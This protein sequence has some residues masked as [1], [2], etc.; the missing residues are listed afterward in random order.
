MTLPLFSVGKHAARLRIDD[1]GI[2][3]VLEDV[4]PVL[5]L[6]LGCHT[7]AD[8]LGKPVDVDGEQVELFLDLL[9]HGFAPGL[10]AEEAGLDPQ[11]RGIQP[12]LPRPLGQEQ[13]VRRRA[14]EDGCLEVLQDG[15]LALRVAPGNGDHGGSDAPS[16]VVH[17]QSAGEK[18]VAV[19]VLHD[20]VPG[21]AAGG[22]RAGHHLGPYVDVA[23]RVCVHHGLSR[24]ARRGVDLHDLVHVGGQKAV[25]VHLPHLVLGCEGKPRNVLDRL[26]VV[27]LHPLLFHLLLIEGNPPVEGVDEPAEP[28]ALQLVHACAR[29]GLEIGVPDHDVPPLVR[30]A[31]RRLQSVYLPIGDEM[32]LCCLESFLRFGELLHLE[33]DGGP[34][35]L[36]DHEAVAVLNVHI[37][38]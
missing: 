24:R 33:D 13:G 12:F 25:G 4:K 11:L 2:E 30:P 27:G 35:A 32:D 34:L 15:E 22:E 18:P 38:G 9:A 5:L 29:E 14:G 37:V 16:S 3:V 1:L 36:F 8:D 7:R 6:A 21:G 23:R 17:A 10:R 20:V 26:D 28:L 31:G 19:G